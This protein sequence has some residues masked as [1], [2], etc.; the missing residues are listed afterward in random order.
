M[1]RQISVRLRNNFIQIRSAVLKL[2]HADRQT[3]RRGSQCARFCKFQ[4]RTRLKK[5]RKTVKSFM[6]STS[7]F[8]PNTFLQHNASYTIHNML[9]LGC[10]A[11]PATTTRSECVNFSGILQTAS[12]V[13]DAEAVIAS[14]DVCRNDHKC[15]D[16]K[17]AEGS[18]HGQQGLRENTES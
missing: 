3:D 13:T 9:L 1:C 5:S 12:R 11:P 17:D 15:Q 10:N 7:P 18:S 2:L 14:N 6:Y 8:S 4:L 16:K